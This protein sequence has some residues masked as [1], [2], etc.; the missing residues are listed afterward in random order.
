MTKIISPSPIL[1][2]FVRAVDEKLPSTQVNKLDSYQAAIEKTTGAE[3][4]RRARHCAHWAFEVAGDKDLGH[5]DWHKIK[6]AHELWKDM[7]FGVEFAEMRDGAGKP[8][9]REDV[10]IEWVE[11]AVNVAKAVGQTLG[12]EHAPWEELLAELIDMEPATT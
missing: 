12:W 10:E 9:P 1:Q 11:D 4:R 8:A 3:D 6:E 7:W 2:A 5:P